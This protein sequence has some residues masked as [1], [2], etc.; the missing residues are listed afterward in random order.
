MGSSGGH[1]RGCARPSFPSSRSPWSRFTDEVW[2]VAPGAAQYI[3]TNVKVSYAGATQYTFSA[4]PVLLTGL[5]PGR[6]MVLAIRADVGTRADGSSSGRG[7]F[8]PAHPDTSLV[9]VL[10]LAGRQ[11]AAGNYVFFSGDRTRNIDGQ[12][13]GKVQLITVG[14]NGDRGAFTGFEDIYLP[15]PPNPGE[16]TPDYNDSGVLSIGAVALP[17]SGQSIPGRAGSTS[18]T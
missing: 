3:G 18:L 9:P 14:G 13:H 2:L 8:D 5:T 6:E 11:Q 17:P 4:V 1:A 10:S 7:L 15:A 12:P 16:P